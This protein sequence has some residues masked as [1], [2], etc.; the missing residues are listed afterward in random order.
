MNLA[1]HHNTNTFCENVGA[2]WLTWDDLSA[3]RASINVHLNE[4]V[5]AE[6]D[7]MLPGKWMLEPEKCRVP[8]P[9]ENKRHLG[10]MP[11]MSAAARKKNI[12]D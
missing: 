5:L 7:A 2:L 3:P 12:T 10:K 1:P 8:P 11:H 4:Y 6:A 9:S